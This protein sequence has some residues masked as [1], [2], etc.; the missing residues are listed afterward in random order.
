VTAIVGEIVTST[1][2]VSVAGTKPGF[3][4]GRVE[5]TKSG[6]AVTA[7]ESTSTEMQEVRSSEMRRIIFLNMGTFCSFEGLIPERATSMD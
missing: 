4:G 7:A 3:V 1:V 6:P 5:V 2:G